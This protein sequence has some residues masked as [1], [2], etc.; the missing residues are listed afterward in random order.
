MKLLIQCVLTCCI[1]LVLH[2]GQCVKKQDIFKIFHRGREAYDKL[3]TS[4]RNGANM[5]LQECRSQFRYRKWNCT[6]NIETNVKIKLPNWTNIPATRETAFAHSIT[7]AGVTYSLTRDCRMG[8]FEDCSCVH[9]KDSAAKGNWWGGCNENIKFGEVMAK[10]F[11]EA[12]DKGNGARTLLILH[13]NEVGRKAVRTTLKKQCRCHGMT[14]SCTTVTCWRKLAVF[15]E[16]GNY[17]K[18]K[19]TQAKR[20][21]IIRNKLKRKGSNGFKTISKKDTNLLY[22]ES[23]P[24]YCQRNMTFGAVGMIGRVC[25]GTKKNLDQC[26]K[27]CSSCGLTSTNF[28]EKKRVICHCKFEWCCKVKCETCRR[29]EVKT[30]C[31]RNI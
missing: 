11:L 29:S 8:K 15:E 9:N 3:L 1:V 6:L 24:D 23:S 30:K 12:I 5:G 18:K 14:G 26:R 28:I 10:H 16:V 19:Y 7:T 25:E 2:Q 13:N 22:T 20:V 31:T 17:L 27:I 4:V 21:S